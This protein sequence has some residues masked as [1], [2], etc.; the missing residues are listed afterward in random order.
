MINVERVRSIKV[1]PTTDKN[2]AIAVI[3][4][5]TKEVLAMSKDFKEP[6]VI[7]KSYYID[8]LFSIADLD[9]KEVA[10][11]N[12]LPL[13][14]VMIEVQ[15]HALGDQLAWLPIID[16]FQKKHNCQVIVNTKLHE[17]FQPFY[18]NLELRWS[19]EVVVVEAIFVL[20]YDVTGKNKTIS[21]V[22][23]RTV[24]LQH[25]ACHQLGIEPQEVRPHYPSPIKRKIVKG[26]Y[27]VISTCGTAR[28]KLWNN[29]AG[30]QGVIDY[31]NAKGY[32]VI[33][34]GDV[35]DGLEGTIS[36]NGILP[37]DELTN[38]IQH[39]SLFVSASNGLQWLAWCVGQTVV[40][41]NNITARGTEFDHIK[42]D[43]KAVCNSC[44]N[45]TNYVFDNMDVNYCP[46]KQDF[47]CSKSI[48]SEMVIKE[49][50]KLEL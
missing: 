39:A 40:T 1:T 5:K 44:W 46:R 17:F 6:I 12:M 4:N 15:S 50:D 32:K 30:W 42:I 36:M 13:N 34:V 9:T 23:C 14:S 48:T 2:L 22:D 26:K 29:P 20:G 16:L 11:L 21:P 8:L 18:P 41:I 47:I 45:D 33:D 28:F 37:L 3:D 24:P 7:P 27:V 25:L 35:T 43:N 10:P 49:L 38:I 19:E 31:F